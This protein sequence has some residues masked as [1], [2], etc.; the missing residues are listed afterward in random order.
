MVKQTKDTELRISIMVIKDDELATERFK[1]GVEWNL[2]VFLPVHVV[3]GVSGHV[4][5]P[6]W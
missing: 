1:N 6:S 5:S 3:A 4:Q 2:T